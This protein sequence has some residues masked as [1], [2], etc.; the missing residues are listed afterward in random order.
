MLLVTQALVDHLGSVVEK[1]SKKGISSHRTKCTA[2]INSVIGPVVHEDLLEDIGNGPYS[3][4]V[5]QVKYKLVLLT[6]V[7]KYQRGHVLI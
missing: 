7:R 4:I 3:L 5:V 2:L 6:R 1:I